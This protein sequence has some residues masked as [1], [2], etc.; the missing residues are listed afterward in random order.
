MILLC[1]RLRLQRLVRRAKDGRAVSLM[2]TLCAKESE[3]RDGTVDSTAAPI[4]V[5]L[6][7]QISRDSS[8]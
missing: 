2:A 3:V 7:P 1:V 5:I 8:F 4:S 6:P